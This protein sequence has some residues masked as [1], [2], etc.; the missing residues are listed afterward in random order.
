MI[1]LAIVQLLHIKIRPNNINV[2]IVAG[3]K[4]IPLGVVRITITVKEVNTQVDAFVSLGD[5]I[6]LGLDW[7][8]QTCCLHDVPKRC[9]NFNVHGRD[10]VVVNLSFVMLKASMSFLN[11][12]QANNFC[13]TMGKAY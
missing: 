11:I 10:F 1:P 12:A 4:Y 8:S 3:N 6:L 9:M 2:T 7:M 5:N 13:E